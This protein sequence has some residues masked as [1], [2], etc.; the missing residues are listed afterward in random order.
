MNLNTV[1]TLLG[2]LAF[3]LFGMR[4]M[5]EGLE[6]AAGPKLKHF[7]E[8]MTH[9][10]LI[11]LV[12]GI[13]VT[14]VIQ[15]SGA[16]T[17]MVVGFVNAQLL[18]LSQSVG[19]IMGANIGTTVTS[20]LLSIKFDPGPVFAFC[21]ILMITAFGKRE[22]VKQAGTVFMGLGVLFIGMDLMSASTEP[23]K[24]W[25]V[26]IQLMQGVRNPLLGLAVGAAVTAL[27]QSSSVSVGI[28][29]VLAAG[30]LVSLEGAL[31]LLLGA[32]I[33]AC[34]PSLLAMA[35]SS[36]SA[37]R[38][39]MINLLFNVAGASLI[40]IASA[41]LPL[42]G[43]AGRLIPDNPK[44]CVSFM[45]IFSSVACTL[46]LLPVSDWLVKLS[47]FVIRGEDTEKTPI[48]MQF[49]DERLLKTP[50]LAAEQLYREVCRMGR[51][52]REHLALAVDALRAA[53]L[54]KEQEINAHEELADYLEES[55]TEG[56]VAVMPLD[57]TE[58]MSKRVAELFHVVT[59]LERISDHAMNLFNLAKE[60]V[61]KGAKISEKADQELEELYGHAM[62]VLDSAL[63]GLEEWAVSDSIM[64]LLEEE[65]QRVDDLTE[66]LRKK[67]ID[68]LKEHKC[69]PKAGIIFLEAISNLERVADHAVNIASCAREDALHTHNPPNPANP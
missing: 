23:L 6:R 22:T 47:C 37:K 20:L 43:L 33:G 9:N 26:F 54:S 46:L 21:G 65:E 55:I 53:D 29:Q 60:R 58:H 4:V 51:E 31:Y 52:S 3:F 32:K 13:C 44:L 12:T 39:A 67:H 19:V 35:N 5:G 36:V 2:G 57:L 66:A 56:L 28:V 48:K 42:S 24:E 49:Y 10:R 30:G 41:F 18:T 38:T 1:I 40:L 25:P 50:T 14:A 11:A 15:S 34:T 69:A 62:K 17:V 8:L 63:V 27:L 45:H 64:T 68:R 59:D 7:L 16:T 61:A